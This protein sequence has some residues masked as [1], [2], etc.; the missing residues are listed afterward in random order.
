MRLSEACRLVW[1]LADE[2][3]GVPT[4]QYLSHFS[5]YT[6]FAGCGAVVWCVQDESFGLPAPVALPFMPSRCFL[7]SLPPLSHWT[8]RYN[9]TPT[10]WSQLATHA[11]NTLV[12]E[13][14]HTH[15]SHTRA[16]THTHTHTQKTYTHTAP[17]LLPH[18]TFLL[19]FS[20]KEKHLWNQHFI[21]ILKSKRTILKYFRWVLLPFLASI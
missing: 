14:I 2:L 1:P 11:H 21:C 15:I 7:L 16:L 20:W 19:F 5:P 9:S 10:P 17:F 3:S 4:V 18:S 8:G 13:H 12:R 6:L